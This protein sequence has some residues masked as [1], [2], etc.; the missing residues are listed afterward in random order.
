MQSSDDLWKLSYKELAYKC[1]ELGQ[2]SLSAMDTGVNQEARRLYGGWSAAFAIDKDA[3]DAAERRAAAT[4][5]L[6]KRTIELL[7]KAEQR[8][9]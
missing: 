3:N 5:S 6:R 7:L 4:T 2:P 8:T 1:Q 9:A